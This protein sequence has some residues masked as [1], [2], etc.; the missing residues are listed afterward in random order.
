MLYCDMLWLRVSTYNQLYPRKPTE[1]VEGNNAHSDISFLKR[2]DWSIITS[3]NGSQRVRR[4]E[5]CEIMLKLGRNPPKSTE[6]NSHRHRHRVQDDL[7]VQMRGFQVVVSYIQRVGMG[8]GW[9]N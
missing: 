7:S 1:R 3:V 2:P 8:M 5:I 4:E 6:D 9:E